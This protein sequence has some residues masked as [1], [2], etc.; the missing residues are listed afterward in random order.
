MLL[1]TDSHGVHGVLYELHPGVAFLLGAGQYLH[2]LWLLYARCDQEQTPLLI[3]HLTHNQLLQGDHRGP[4]VL[5]DG[6]VGME[7]KERGKNGVRGKR[8]REREGR[9][10][11]VKDVLT[12]FLLKDV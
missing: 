2:H 5:G 10:M 8:E 6:R 11:E 9:R 7:G 3:S 12:R 4:L 1:L